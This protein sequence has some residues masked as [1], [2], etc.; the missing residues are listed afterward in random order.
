MANQPEAPAPAAAKAESPK[1]SGSPVATAIGILLTAVLAGGAAFGGAKMGSRGAA[2]AAAHESDPHDLK[3]PH[4]KAPGATIALEP[5]L[6]TV[7]DAE[8]KQRAIKVTLA[9]ELKPEEKEDA[10]K[11]FVPRIRDATLGY[12]R[13][14]SFEEAADSAR[15]EKM[16]TELLERCEKLGAYAVEKVL[17]TD[18]VTQ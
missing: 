9:L 11:P 12:L 2:P 7:A 8:G 1:R 3:P 17:I 18:F 5:F 16:R 13:A 14:L 4:P 6:L 10:F 15:V